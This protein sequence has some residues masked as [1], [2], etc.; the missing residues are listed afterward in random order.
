MRHTAQHGY[1][2]GVLLE[3]LPRNTHPDEVDT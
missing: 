3:A 2:I 1:E